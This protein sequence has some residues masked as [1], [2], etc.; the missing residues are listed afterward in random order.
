MLDILKKKKGQPR[1]LVNIL[2]KHAKCLL[3]IYTLDLQVRH[4]VHLGYGNLNQGAWTILCLSV[5]S[6]PPD[7]RLGASIVLEAEMEPQRLEKMLLDSPTNVDWDFEVLQLSDDSRSLHTPFLPGIVRARCLVPR[8]V[9]SL[10]RVSEARPCKPLPLYRPQRLSLP[11]VAPI[12]DDA[13]VVEGDPDPEHP[14][15]VS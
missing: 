8:S 6:E 14:D 4:I 2:N 15:E 13:S 1:S 5:L 7:E 11:L 12:A 9:H 10:W 3:D